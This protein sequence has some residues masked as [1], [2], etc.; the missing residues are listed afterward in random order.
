MFWFDPSSGLSSAILAGL[1]LYGLWNFRKA[2]AAWWNPAGALFGLGVLWA[3]G[4][5][6]WSF[7]PAGSARD[8]I[9]SLP[10]A[11]AAFAVPAAF[12]RPSRIWTALVASAGLVTARV[13]ADLV[14]LLTELGWPAVLTDARFF[15]PYLYTHPNAASM[16]AGLCVLVFAARWMAGAP[17]AWR[18]ALLAAGIA[19]NLAYLLMMASRGPQ[20]AFAATALAFPVILFPDGRARLAA[21][22]LALALGFG[23]WQVADELNPRFRDNTMSTFNDRDVVW[24]HAKMLADRRPTAGY[25]FGKKAFVKAVYEN[26]AQDAPAV[27]VHYPHTHN[28]WL[29]L[30]FQSGLVGLA[31][32]GAGWL[33]TA[34]RL[35]WFARCAD[36]VAAGRKGRIRARVLPALLGTG[37]AFILLYGVGDFPDHAIRH[38]QFYLL[39]LAMALMASPKPETA[40][41]P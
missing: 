26:P 12:D 28:Y 40:P 16:M 30:Y 36:P 7:H 8:L 20:I 25:G 29:M 19:G 6:A 2:L 31:C 24:K 22:V 11:L 23:L 35:G 33:A 38:A 13:V 17:G 10:M 21:G 18:K 4:S 39:G 3:I 14:R 41:A 37:L 34:L 9:K 27:R 1:G 5:I 15:H 32:W